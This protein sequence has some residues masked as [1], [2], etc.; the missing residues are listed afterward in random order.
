MNFELK[1]NELKEKVGKQF[2]EANKYKLAMTTFKK[3]NKLKVSLGNK[4]IG[5]DTIIFNLG[6]A[7]ECPSALLDM[8]ELAPKEL[9]G[10]GKCY[11]LKAERMYPNSWV[12]RRIQRIQ[13]QLWTAEKIAADMITIIKTRRSNPI[14]FIRL[15]ESGDFSN[16]EDIKKL[17]IIAR[18]VG[19]AYPK[20]KF[21]TYSHRKDLRT[22]F[23]TLPGNVTINGSGFMI[24]NEYHINSEIP[25][26]L[27]PELARDQMVCLDDCSTCNLCKVQH[28]QE[29]LQTIH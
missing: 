21:Y 11:A 28:G 22:K 13:W 26:E 19:E 8:C 29:I 20:I 5:K 15:N 1:I 6:P 17:G 3:I 23:L 14:K 12:F 2:P 24:H 4:K 27:K 16:F 10:N 9:G 7:K 25:Y 18:L